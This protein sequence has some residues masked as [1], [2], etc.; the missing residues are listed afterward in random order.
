MNGLQMSPPKWVQAAINSHVLCQTSALFQEQ[1]QLFQVLWLK[2]AL[3][4]SERMQKRTVLV[5]YKQFRL[6]DP[7]IS[8]ITTFLHRERKIAP[9]P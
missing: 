3:C 8:G 7:E 5:P 2:V 1:A 9:K 6:S 4:E